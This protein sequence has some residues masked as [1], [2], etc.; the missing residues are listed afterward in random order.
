MHGKAVGNSKIGLF[1]GGNN[2]INGDNVWQRY[3]I[4]LAVIFN[5]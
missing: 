1:L 5:D 3:R 2:G 4:H